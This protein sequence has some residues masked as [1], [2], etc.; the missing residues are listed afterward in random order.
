MLAFEHDTDTKTIFDIKRILRV[1]IK[2][3]PL[4]KLNLI[5]Q[6][7]RCQ[8]HG[9]TQ[10]FCRI[11]PRCVKCSGKYITTECRNPKEA[12]PKCTNCNPASYRGFLV[13]K[14]LQER[15]NKVVQVKHQET[16]SEK[17]QP[18]KYNNVNG[19]I[20]YAQSISQSNQRDTKEDEA[21]TNANYYLN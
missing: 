9:H 3:E 16:M 4:K 15:R 21:T 10:K 13:A 7:K 2:I 18:E 5:P 19:E 17:K 1:E 6:C 11:E 20:T 14:T 8:L 12:K